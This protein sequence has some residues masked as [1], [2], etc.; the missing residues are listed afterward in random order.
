MGFNDKPLDM[1]D[2]SDL[3]ALVDNQVPEGKDI[4]YKVVLHGNSEGEK[5]E[6][7]ADVSS[8]ANALGGSLIFGIADENGMPV[9]LPGLDVVNPDAEILRM[10]N[11][12]L[13]GIEPR[14]TVQTRAIRLQSGRVGIVMRIPRSWIGPHRVKYQRWAKF[15]S[16]TSNGKYELDVGELRAAFLRSESVVERIRGFRADRVAKIIA[17]AT[18]T[19]L[20]RAPTLVL[21]LVSLGGFDPAA[22]LP[23]ATLW[24]DM[25]A[26]PALQPMNSGITTHRHNFDGFLTVGKG[27]GDTAP[28]GYVQVFRNGC[29][30]SVDCTSLQVSDGSAFI[31]TTAYE[32]NLIRMVPKY[33]SVQRHL[34]VDLPMLAMIT[35]TGVAGYSMWVDASLQFLN[36]SN[37]I[38][39]DVLFLPEVL[40]EEYEVEPA[41][42]LKESFDSVWNAAGWPRSLNYDD[43]GM[44]RRS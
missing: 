37:P 16:R 10:E 14:L 12:L 29:I 22:R 17:G 6:Y 43:S 34:G 24:N 3:H 35:L 23:V 11:A 18:P 20:V 21:H 40:I 2:E 19:T 39:R 5:K 38:D 42:L 44:W 32:H 13:D 4:D 15:F 31:P 41:E 30:E 27:R 33:L 28:I 36:R 9:E 7:F 26:F 8:F 1:L 25:A